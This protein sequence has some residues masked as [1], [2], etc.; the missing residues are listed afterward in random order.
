MPVEMWDE[1]TYPFSNLYGYT[2]DVLKRGS[3]SISHL[4]LDEIT[5]PSWDLSQTMFVN[6]A[7]GRMLSSSLSKWFCM[8]VST[9]K[10]YQC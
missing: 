5:H 3:N 1:F 9:T 4:I 7:L 8:P 2:V 10:P 6:G